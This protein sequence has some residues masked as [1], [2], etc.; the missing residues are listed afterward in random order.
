MRFSNDAIP[1]TQP[2][3]GHRVKGLAK[4][5]VERT[6][7]KAKS[8]DAVPSQAEGGYSPMTGQYFTRARPVSTSRSG[9]SL[10]G[11]QQLLGA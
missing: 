6:M 9:L 3:L 5:V 1:P 7:A 11:L 2:G 4:P 8:V 10:G